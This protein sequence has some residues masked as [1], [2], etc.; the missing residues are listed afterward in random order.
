MKTKLFI[1]CALISL[2]AIASAQA[3][4]PNRMSALWQAA[5]ERLTTQYDDWF[6]VGDYPRIVSALQYLH[7]FEPTDYETLTNLGWMLENIDRSDEALA[8]YIDYR[9]KNPHIE[10]AE[11]PEVNFYYSRKLYTK[12]PQLVE[13]KIAAKQSG[14]FAIRMLAH[15]Y[16]KMNLLSDSQRAWNE[17]LA[18]SPSDLAA[19]ANLKRVEKKLQSAKS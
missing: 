19:K 16:E 4:D 7:E 3:P 8:L 6:K 12:V 5:D 18:I 14:P 15:A 17:Y 9:K 2:G 1:V 13:P 10:D 11:F